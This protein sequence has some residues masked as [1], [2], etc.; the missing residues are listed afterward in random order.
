MELKLL[1]NREFYF[2]PICGSAKIVRPLLQKKVRRD[3]RAGPAFHEKWHSIGSCISFVATRIPC[4]SEVH[5]CSGEEGRRLLS[6]LTTDLHDHGTLMPASFAQNH[7]SH[8]FTPFTQSRHPY[9]TQ[10]LEYLMEGSPDLAP[11]YGV[12]PWSHAW[13]FLCI[14]VDYERSSSMLSWLRMWWSWQGCTTWL[15]ILYGHFLLQLFSP[16]HEH[17]ALGHK[18]ATSDAPRAETARAVNGVVIITHLFLCNA[19]CIAKCFARCIA[20]CI[21]RPSVRSILLAA[22]QRSMICIFTWSYGLKWHY[23]FIELRTFYGRHGSRDAHHETSPH[24]FP[25]GNCGGISVDF[26]FLQVYGVLQRWH[27]SCEK[28]R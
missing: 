8:V 18:A 7:E 23:A 3:F 20:K 9:L 4:I 28:T 26:L 13:V 25:H 21:W 24:N 11:G 22:S 16:V 17:K 10:D 5:P 19:K 15:H 1:D 14:H 12:L 27:N 6:T 2:C